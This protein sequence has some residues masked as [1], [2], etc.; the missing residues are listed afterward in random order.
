MKPTKPLCLLLAITLLAL[1]PKWTHGDPSPAPTSQPAL[2][3]EFIRFVED[4]AGGGKLETAIVTYTNPAGVTLHLVGAL[5]VG[6]KAYY[7]GLN[8]S[9]S[10]YCVLLYEMIKPKGSAAPVRGQ[11]SRS[12]IGGF[13]RFLKDAL[14]LDY[15]LDD[16]DYTQP[17]FVHADLDWETFEAMQDERGESIFGIM[18]RSM[19]HDMER[20]AE[21]KARKAEPVTLLDLLVAMRARIGPGNSS[22]CWPI[23]SRI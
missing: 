23:N 8:N 6:E 15:Q 2:D 13:Q 12:A 3:T 9:F 22:S 20:Q 21:G 19:L 10:K 5:H 17:N 7:E 11:R 1:M 18:L 4:G 16:I 14:A